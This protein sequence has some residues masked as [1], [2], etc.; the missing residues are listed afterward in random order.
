MQQHPHVYQV[1]AAGSPDET[2]AVASPRLP[3]IP[4][5]PPREFDGPGGV[6]SPETLHRNKNPGAVPGSMSSDQRFRRLKT[7][8][9]A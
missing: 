6:G 3:A 5:A 7:I 1:S 9:S 4:T 8:I 2:V